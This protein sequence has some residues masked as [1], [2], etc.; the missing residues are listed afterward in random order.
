VALGLPSPGAVRAQSDLENGDINGD[1]RRDISDVIALA[2]F[3]FLG[4]PSPVAIVCA[5]AEDCEPE[6][7][8]SSFESQHYGSLDLQ[9]AAVDQYGPL[10]TVVKTGDHLFDWK[11][12]VGRELFPLDIER[13]VGAQYGRGWMPVVT[14]VHA[15]DW[16]AFRF[17]DPEHMVL[18]VMLIASDRVFEVAGV[19]R[20]VQRFR[21]VV[22]RV[23]S[24]YNGRVE[25]RMRVLQP[26][27]VFTGLSSAQW[28]ELSE[29]TDDGEQFRFVFLDECVKAYESGLPAAG[30]NLKV[31]ISVYSGES[32]DVWLGAAMRG[33]Y[34]V[35]PPRAT[36]VDCPAAG[37]LNLRCADAAY[38]VGHE[39]GHA[40]GLGHSCDEF[41]DHPR[42]S[43]SIMQ[44]G[45][46]PSA[47]LLQREACILLDS[48]FFHPLASASLRPALDGP[49]PRD[50]D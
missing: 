20:A 14:G 2:D 42:C 38:A 31:V 19:E 28:N 22:G 13:A 35:A 17:S 4:G 21:S 10:A 27:V 25:G 30:E 23:Q 46:P 15:F 9:R 16:R 29:R 26:L 1:G 7:P 43:E 49:P 45:K 5:G 50:R 48:P 33:R 44:L 36:S 41:P 6:E 18:P 32:P 39:L 24:W 12:R 37:P 34:A 40:F 11:A 3:L 8:P 47:I